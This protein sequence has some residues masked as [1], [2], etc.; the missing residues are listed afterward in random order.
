MAKKFPGMTSSLYT[1]TGMLRLEAK[2]VNNGHEERDALEW[3][4]T[5]GEKKD[6][7]SRTQV[8]NDPGEHFR[9]S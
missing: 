9:C 8:Q 3:E 1:E 7:S 4:R 6:F 2:P 5:L